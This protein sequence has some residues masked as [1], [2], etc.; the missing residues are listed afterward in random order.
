[1]VPVFAVT[2]RKAL[3]IRREKLC[4][5]A[6]IAREFLRFIPGRIQ[7]D[8]NVLLRGIELNRQSCSFAWAV[9]V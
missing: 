3:I 2:H 8:A 6:R 1:M 9:S 5:S 4:R 7:A